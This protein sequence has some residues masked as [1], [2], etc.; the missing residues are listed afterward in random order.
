M[1][2]A[3]DDEPS[4]GP[5]PVVVGIRGDD[6]CLAPLRWAARAAQARGVE[7]EALM[8]WE[9][10]ELPQ[11]MPA[12]VREA[13]DDVLEDVR[14]ALEAAVD[15][16]GISQ[17][18]GLKI[19][20]TVVASTAKVALAQVTWRADLLVLGASPH[21]AAYAPFSTGRR[22]AATVASCPVVL[23][24]ADSDD[25]A[26]S[27]TAS[28]D[29]FV[30]GVD[31]SP[32]SVGALAWACEEAAR[33]SLPVRVVHV[34]PKQR[35]PEVDKAVAREQR[36]HPSL[37]IAL[38]D[39]VGDPGEVLAAESAGAEALVLGQH[40]S[41]WLGRQL[42]SLGSVSRWCAAYP[43]CPVVIVPLDEHADRDNALS[44]GR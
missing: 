5:K 27:S 7:L 43:V 24:P 39:R 44:V 18:P 6:S 10:P 9:L 40:G 35:A 31:G 36:A 33:R 12:D 37:V 17:Q 16:S 42:P 38:T 21:S 8:A 25:A 41:G 32:Q 1:S 29:R 20:T 34:G 13:S 14:W 19:S 22:T 3:V 26:A 30:V 11:H 2:R 23:V 28:G 4:A 15:R